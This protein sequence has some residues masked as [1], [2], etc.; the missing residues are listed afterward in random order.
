MQ[1]Q[2]SGIHIDIG[3]ALQTH[4]TGELN[5]SISKYAERPTDAQIIF[6]KS[7]H[8]FVCDAIIHLS[9]GLTAQAKA[10]KVEIYD[11]FDACAEK[12][13]KQLRR[14]KR[15]LK[16]HHKNRLQSVEFVEPASYTDQIKER[17]QDS[18]FDSKAI[19]VAETNK[20][21]PILSVKDA[22]DELETFNLPFLLFKSEENKGVNILF[23]RQDGNLGWVQPS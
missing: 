10:S 3:D 23:R 6:S 17:R 18:T 2:I 7:G 9:T 21:F 20:D 19:I 5:N 13:K 16:S 14:Y 1:Y 22:A 8:E 4:V 12:V 15:K 11:A